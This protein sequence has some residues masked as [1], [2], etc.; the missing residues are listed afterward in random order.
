MWLPFLILE[1]APVLIMYWGIKAWLR[2]QR[3][4]EAS[5]GTH[6]SLVS[7][8]SSPKRTH[9]VLEFTTS[10]GEKVETRSAH[11]MRRRTDPGSAV[12]VRYLPGSP[13]TAWI[14]GEAEAESRFQLLFSLILPV[15]WTVIMA[16]Y[17]F[18]E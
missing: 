13:T 6:G 18:F 12:K 14:E 3:N 5:R 17:A 2:T 4:I 1:I 8:K 15:M 9:A 10:T 7:L 11:V 16:W